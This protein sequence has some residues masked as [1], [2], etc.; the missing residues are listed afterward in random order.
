MNN[1]TLSPPPGPSSLL[2]GCKNSIFSRRDSFLKLYPWVPRSSFSFVPNE[3]PRTTLRSIC[4]VLSVH[5]I[6]DI[7]SP[8]HCKLIFDEGFCRAIA[9]LFSPVLDLASLYFDEA[10]TP[11]FPE[12][13]R[14]KLV[15]ASGP[16]MPNQFFSSKTISHFLLP[17]S[18]AASMLK[19]D[20]FQS[21]N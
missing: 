7:Q 21:G 14:A 2:S 8:R 10:G 11:S 20:C 4:M 1:H 19:S 5:D 17:G 13:I 15:V 12:P 16:R 18:C 3:Y 9:F 6:R